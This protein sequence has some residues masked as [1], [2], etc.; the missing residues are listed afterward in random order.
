MGR[1]A[2]RELVVSDA[3]TA[4]AVGSGSLPVLGT[5]VLLAWCESATCAALELPEGQT[6]VGTRVSLEHLAASPVGQ[7]VT[8]TATVAYVDGRLVRFTVEARMGD[9][10]VGTGEITRVVVDA[11][12][13]M[14]RL[15]G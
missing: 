4:V 10:L 13:F 3:D 7:T 12:R 15:G 9:K 2:T 5:P 6:S 11:E 8:V 14:S 1:T